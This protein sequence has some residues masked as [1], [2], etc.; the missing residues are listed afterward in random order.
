M[1]ATFSFATNLII[2]TELNDLVDEDEM[3]SVDGTRLG[4]K[5]LFQ[6]SYDEFDSSVFPLRSIYT[7]ERSD[8]LGQLVKEKQPLTIETNSGV[9]AYRMSTE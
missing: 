3:D 8:S 6:R 2:F 9:A 7:K 1:L 5:R 4:A